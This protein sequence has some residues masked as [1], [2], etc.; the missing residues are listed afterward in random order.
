MDPISIG[1]SVVSGVFGWFKKKQADKAAQETVRYINE[2]GTKADASTDAAKAASDT[3][4]DYGY[5][6][7]STA[8]T[9]ADNYLRMAPFQTQ[10]L[11]KQIGTNSGLADPDILKRPSKNAYNENNQIGPAQATNIT[12]P[13]SPDLSYTTIDTVGGIGAMGGDAGAVGGDGM[14]G[15]FGDAGGFGSG[16]AG[17]LGQG[18]GVGIGVGLGDGGSLGS[19]GSGGFGGF[20]GLGDGGALGG[21]MGGG[22][23]G[24]GSEG[25]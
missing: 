14:G 5:E 13:G 12:P 3:K 25:E 17:G 8:G 24:G 2:A 16:D 19:V 10:E 9:E 7:P 4:I 15:S 18:M 6:V 1:A 11:G 22:D 20:G 23:V 21:G